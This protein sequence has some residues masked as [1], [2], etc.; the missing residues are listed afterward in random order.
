MSDAFRM[1]HE[2]ELRVG[3]S[4][5]LCH[6]HQGTDTCAKC[7]PG[8]VQSLNAQQQPISASDIAS[9]RKPLKHNIGSCVIVNKSVYEGFY[10]RI[11]ESSRERTETTTRDERNQEEVRTAGASGV[12]SNRH[13][14]VW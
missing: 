2:D 5:F 13:C 14:A 3:D 9:L 7:E 10:V 1:E 8:C 4:V 12:V 6:I 11:F